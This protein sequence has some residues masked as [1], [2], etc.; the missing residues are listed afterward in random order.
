MNQE[1]LLSVFETIFY[2]KMIN[3]E[4]LNYNDKSLILLIQK[5]N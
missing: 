5:P 1:S 2:F 4:R 3:M